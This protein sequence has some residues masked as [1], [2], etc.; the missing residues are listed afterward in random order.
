MNKFTNILINSLLLVSTVALSNA[1][2]T[3]DPAP[4]SA[5]TPAQALS[6]HLVETTEQSIS[7]RMQH[8]QLNSNIHDSTIQTRK[9]HQ[10]VT[11]D[12]NSADADPQP[13]QPR[14]ICPLAE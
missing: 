14:L 3:T 8:K 1:T 7:G 2:K 9:P 12:S 10:A 13:S 6:F 5:S 4:N 11:Q